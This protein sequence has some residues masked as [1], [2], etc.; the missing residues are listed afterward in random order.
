MNRWIQYTKK[1]CMLAFIAMAV[2][3]SYEM[4]RNE[5][6]L[7]PYREAI[8]GI[9][10]D[11]YIIK[12]QGV[13][14][15]DVSTVPTNTLA[16]TEPG[17]QS[18]TGTR[19]I[20]ASGS[21]GGKNV[22]PGTEYTPVMTVSE[23]IVG[24]LGGSKITLLANQSTSQM[25]SVLIETNQGKII[26]LD[27]GT[28][29][30]TTHLV[31]T[32]AA[33]GS[34]VDTWLITHPHSDHVGALNEILNHPEYGVTVDHV[35][36]SFAGLSWYQEYEPGRADMV[37]KIM[38]SLSLQP[39]EK[40]HGDIYRGQEIWVDNIKI[41]VM[42]QPY[43][44]ANNSINNS[45]VAY[46]LDINGKKALFLGDMGVETGKQFLADHTPEELKC[47]IVQMAHHGQDGVG[48]EVYQVLQP[49]ICLWGA[50]DWL[51]NNDSG[52]GTDSGKWKTIETRKWMAQL[53]VPYHVCIK[54]G[55]QIIQ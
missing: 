28:P 3:S 20:R 32:L 23:P 21:S 45:S 12:K 15:M 4:L 29:E 17:S 35:Y 42:N 46:M 47:D 8:E 30:D 53:G 49:Q 2:P 11:E 13:M 36:F 9:V 51:W 54:D 33:K 16:G 10:S 1:V 19:V 5:A 55:D 39:Q 44:Q 38:T 18:N 7:L 50:P 22:G 6:G 26:M 31:Q 40:V 27:G 14:L 48:L 52:S 43:L 25:L 41:T 34:H 37:A 24:Y